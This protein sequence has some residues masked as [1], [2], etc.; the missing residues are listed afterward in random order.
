MTMQNRREFL[1]TT[2][3]TAAGVAALGSVTSFAADKAGKQKPLFKISCTEYS[4]HR[5]INKKELDNLDYAGFVKETFDIDAVEY[6]NRP[7]FTKAKDKEYIG[8][9]R[10]RADDA[11]VSG[12]C[13]L[14][15]GE[16]DLGDPNEKKRL[17]AVDRHKKWVEAAKKLGCTSI[18]VNARSKGGYEEQ[19]A[20]AADGLAK[21]SEFGKGL[22][23]AVI[24]ENHG[25][26][27]SNGK[28]LAAVMEKV[29]MDNCGTLPDFGNFHD[30]DRYQGTKELMTYAKL[31]S[32]K[33]H[34]FD[35][36]GNETKTDYFKMMKIVMDS[37]YRGYVGIEFEGGGIPEVK[38]VKMTK[39]LL[40][41]VREKLSS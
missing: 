6:W 20:L 2:A 19:L 13:I 9:M 15:D 38:G 10:K 23:M 25:G 8:D 26:L 36:E 35:K 5:M 1:Q 16:G 4:L 37:G 32:A 22:K 21:L 18:R 34:E 24:V 33:S 40:E 28:W 12:T 17:S 31:V 30:Y 27:S 29:G 11:G 7:F 3:Q 14:V 41:R 39:A